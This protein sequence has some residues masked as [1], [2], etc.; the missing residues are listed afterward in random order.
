[1]KSVIK[2]AVITPVGRESATIQDFILDVQSRLLVGEVHYLITDNFTDFETKLVISNL[3][4]KS[5]LSIIWIDRK[6]SEGIASVYL[7]GYKQ[8]LK[9]DFTHFLEIDAGYSHNPAQIASF[10]EA[11][12]KYEVVLGNRFISRG[13]FKTTFGRK[14]L[15]AGGSHIT[16]IFLGLADFDLTSGYQLFSRNA[17]GKILKTGI[18][19]RGPFFQTE[20]K[21]YALRS[22]FSHTEIPIT[23]SNPSRRITFSDVLES[24]LVL[25]R[26]VFR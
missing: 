14:I 19:S 2:L 4:S 1:M 10:R 9:E 20:M 11:A 17:L 16:K 8:A 24:L 6:F 25:M 12:L 22:N 18:L 21:F 23:Y 15:S 3:L 13:A 5:K 7:E 26:L